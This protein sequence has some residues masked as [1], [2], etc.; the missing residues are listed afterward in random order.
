MDAETAVKKG[1][2]RCWAK[3]PR[4]RRPQRVV[5]KLPGFSNGKIMG[6]WKNGDMIYIDM[7]YIDIYIYVYIYIYIYN[8][9]YIQHSMV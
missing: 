9:I 6:E 3:P 2:L 4:L 5:P 8:Y 7:I 1:P